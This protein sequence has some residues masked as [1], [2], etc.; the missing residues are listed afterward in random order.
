MLTSSNRESLQA[1]Y[2]CITF[3]MRSSSRSDVPMHD[4]STGV[5]ATRNVDAFPLARA[6]HD[7]RHNTKV[8]L[9]GEERASLRQQVDVRKEDLTDQLILAFGVRLGPKPPKSVLRKHSSFGSCLQTSSRPLKSV[10]WAMS[11]QRSNLT[12]DTVYTIDSF[13]GEGIDTNSESSAP[14]VPVRSNKCD[15]VFFL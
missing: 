10:T 9:T 13:T 1:R 7:Q 15:H 5:T 6:D 2:C 8:M 11:D 3:Q 14:E 12:L 4:H